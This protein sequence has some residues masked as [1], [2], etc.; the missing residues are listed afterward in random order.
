MILVLFLSLLL[1]SA[2]FMKP[3]IPNK[4]TFFFK[5][6]LKMVDQEIVNTANSFISRGT[7]GLPWTFNDL[8][9]NLKNNNV[10]MATILDNINTV[11][12]L[13]KN[14]DDTITPENLHSIKTLPHLTNTI[15]DRLTEF[16]INFDILK[17]DTSTIFDYIPGPVQ[18]FV[19]YLIFIS[20]INFIRFRNGGGGMG[21]GGPMN[22]V[23]SMMDKETEIINPQDIN[24]TF[25]DV[26][27]CDEAKYELVEVVDFLK[28]ST[29]FEKAG[30]IIP[31]G[32]Y[33]KDHQEPG[34]LY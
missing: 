1:L 6:S 2:G 19:T 9:L 13:D 15:I 27:G 20:F 18:F 14:F 33:L 4:Q 11:V 3:N 32:Y 21:S 28:N 5:N 10:E 29:R 12:A 30:A 22:F 8:L 16:H 7:I 23:T 25:A 34:K 17:Y 31:K 26:A 24:V